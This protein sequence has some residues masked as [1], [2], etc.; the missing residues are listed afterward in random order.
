MGLELP[1]GILVSLEH[2]E[3]FELYFVLGLFFYYEPYCHPGI[4]MS[5]FSYKRICF[6]FRISFAMSLD[7]KTTDDPEIWLLWSPRWEAWLENALIHIWHI[8]LIFLLWKSGC[9]GK[10]R[11]NWCISGSSLRWSQAIARTCSN[12]RDEMCFQHTCLRFDLLSHT[13]WSWLLPDVMRRI[14]VN[15]LGVL[16]SLMN[17]HAFP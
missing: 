14:S 16:F 9:W 12:P 1:L 11:R 7:F 2:W 17:Q 15:S 10:M 5:L 4:W 6:I 3:N 8:Y 13:V